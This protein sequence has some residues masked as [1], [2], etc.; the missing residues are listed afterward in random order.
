ML[1][2]SA[3]P[4]PRRAKHDHDCGTTGWLLRKVIIRKR[5][6]AA[7]NESE[8]T[9]A[10]TCEN[11][12]MLCNTLDVVSQSMSALLAFSADPRCWSALLGYGAVLVCSARQFVSSVLLVS[13]ACVLCSGL[14]A[15]LVAIA[16]LLCSPNVFGVRACR[17]CSAACPR[18]KGEAALWRRHS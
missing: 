7:A 17:L 5:K 11:A 6:R 1:C 2:S 16:E 18:W 12:R 3:R 15:L 10:R 4:P 9:P 13:F 8:G 14:P